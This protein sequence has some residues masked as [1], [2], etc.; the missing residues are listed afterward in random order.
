MRSILS[1]KTG[2]FS[3]H[4]NRGENVP[5]PRCGGYS[6]RIEMLTEE[7]RIEASTC[8]NSGA[9]FG[10]PV[11]DHHTDFRPHLLKGQTY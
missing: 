11:L 9:I 3:C 1:P 8:V 2:D 4:K 10:E 7:E 5:W 6:K